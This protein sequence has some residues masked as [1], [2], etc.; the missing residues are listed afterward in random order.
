MVLN[1]TI[2]IIIVVHTFIEIY[3]HVCYK[4][5]CWEVVSQKVPIHILYTEKSDHH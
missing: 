3:F 5:V 4:Y 2:V 1:S